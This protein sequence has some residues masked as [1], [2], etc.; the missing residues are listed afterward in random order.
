[1]PSA[2]S[3]TW[4]SWLRPFCVCPGCGRLLAHPEDAG[5]LRD[6][7][8]VLVR[9][10]HLSLVRE[11]IAPHAERGDCG[12]RAGNFGERVRHA[13]S[14]WIQDCVH[15]VFLSYRGSRSGKPTRT[16]DSR[17]QRLHRKRLDLKT[18]LAF[19]FQL[20]RPGL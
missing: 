4:L 14:D 3:K 1:M 7:K 20:E 12:F 8:M 13:G 6:E 18:L 9:R 5:H 2:T 11:A 19:R 17:L 10:A 16:C 15:G